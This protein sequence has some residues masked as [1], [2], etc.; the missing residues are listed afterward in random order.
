[1]NLGGLAESLTENPNRRVAITAHKIRGETGV[2]NLRTARYIL[3]Q[4]QQEGILLRSGR[5]ETYYINPNPPSAS[6]PY[7]S[8]F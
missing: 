3:T 2:R 8:R 5:S 1:M 6:S 4:L 7:Y